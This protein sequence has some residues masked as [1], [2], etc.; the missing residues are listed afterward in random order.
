[1]KRPLVACLALL[2]AYVGLSFLNDPRGYLGTDTGAKVATLKVMARR[3]QLDPDVGY[4][5]QRWDPKGRLH[6]LYNTPKI[7]GKW[8]QVTTLPALYAAFPLYRVGG[9]RL[10]LLLP[11][12]G[13]VLAALAARALARRL[14][15]DERTG[16]LAFWVVGVASPLTVYAVDFWEH[17]LGVACIGWAI[18]LLMD[19]ADTRR[20]TSALGAGLLFGLAATMRTEALAYGA[21]LAAAACAVVLLVRRDVVRAV[22]LGALVGVGLVVVMGANIGLERATVGATLRTNRAVGA[23]DLAVTQSTAGDSRIEEAVLTT[24]GLHPQLDASS[25]LIGAAL[26]ALLLLAALRGSPGDPGIARLALVG[27]GLL[28]LLRAADGLGFVPGMVAAAPLTVVGLTAVWGDRWDR[29]LP[30]AAVAAL[31]LVWAFQFTGGAAP[32]WAGR[33]VLPTTFVLVAVGVTRLPSLDIWVRRSFVTLAIAVTAFGVAWLSVRSHDVGTTGEALARRPEPVL[34]S[35]IAHLFR[36]EG[37]WYGDRRWLTVPTSAEEPLLA[38][39]LRGAG[40]DRFGWIDV[41]GARP[42]VL[43]GY[44]ARGRTP[45]PFVA[46]VRLTLTT[47]VR[48][49]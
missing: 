29:R 47:Y 48:S 4:W 45:V 25:Y 35:R 13:S 17:S 31:P 10:A 38:P 21:V 40:V 49:G 46:G 30:L 16:W 8:V 41:A 3:G 9:Y 43:D 11:M 24:V 37:H 39:V 26:L 6:P 44:T 15:A 14:G 2:V 18:V 5:A 32:Q 1:M 22:G 23:A 28:Y 27:A 33:Y 36:E 19:V 42:P 7:H 12:L 20:W 34:V